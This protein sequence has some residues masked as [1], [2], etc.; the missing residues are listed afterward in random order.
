MALLPGSPAIGAGTA[1]AGVTTDQRGVARLATNPDIG[2]FQS[3]GLASQPVFSGLATE[4]ITYGTASVNVVGTLAAGSRVP[5]GGTVAVTLDGVTQDTTIG[6]DGS[7]ST[8][9]ATAA[10]PASP[11]AYTVTYTFAAQGPFLAASGSSGLTVDPAL[12]T[13][14]AD[15]LTIPYG[16]AVPTLTAS[17]AGFVDGQTPA[18]LTTP[19]VLST[20]A[21]SDSPAD[22]YA[23]LVS[24]ASSSNY[25]IRYVHGTLTIA[26]PATPATSQARAAQGFVT[27]LYQDVLGRGAEPSGL[28]YWKRQFLGHLPSRAIWGLFGRSKERRGL[29]REGKAPTIPLGAAYQDALR[30]SRRA[31]RQPKVVPAGPVA[32]LTSRHARASTDGVQVHGPARP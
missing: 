31:A 29:E 26:P 17:Y 5:A 30:A 32:L 4:T 15:S 23:I 19:V 28:R 11:T 2:A 10:I 16:G 14:T 12:L 13:I 18:D 27:T 8:T 3:Q 24:D 21:T 7:F 1:V 25:T 20:S 22:A 9:F 6:P